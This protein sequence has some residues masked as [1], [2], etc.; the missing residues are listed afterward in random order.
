VVLGSVNVDLVVNV[1]RLPSAGE[2]VTGGTF[3]RHHGGK[4]ANQAVAAARLGAPVAF[5]GAVGADEFGQ[6]ARNQLAEE[7]V[8]VSG[9]GAID[10]S[11]T[12]VAFILVDGAGENEIAVASGAN[13]AFDA[14]I[15]DRAPI[16][17]PDDVFVSCFEVGLDALIAGAERF[18]ATGALVVINP[19]PALELP[20]A[21]L[22]TRPILVPNEGEA[23]ALTG[24][25]DPATAARVLSAR[26]GA[27]AIVTLGAMGAV[28]VED[29][30]LVRVAAPVVEVVDTTGAGDAFVGA[31][32][33]ELS[34]GRSLTEAVQFA[35]HAASC[36]VRVAG[37]HEGMPTRPEVERS[38]AGATR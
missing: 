30:E 4:G 22:A 9:L 18:A 33:A 29:G 32:A 14:S 11:S 21:L 7:G 17:Q 35:V 2:T 3:T 5:V 38:M 16:P 36:S 19:A 37:A 1:D 15:W 10:T 34:E 27:P 12:G 6:A 24:E 8:D 28:F 23:Q 13:H 25:S 26:S 31:L 20:S